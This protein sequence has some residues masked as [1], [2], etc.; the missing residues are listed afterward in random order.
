MIR[1]R[2]IAPL[3]IALAITVAGPALAAGAVSPGMATAGPVAMKAC[4]PAPEPASPR[5]G[6]PGQF[7][8]PPATATN[9]DPFADPKV[10]I[11][12]V[13]GYAYRWQTYDN[14]CVPGS[15]AAP[16]MFTGIGN[17]VL[18]SA[19]SVVAFTHGLLGLVVEPTFLAPLDD[20]ITT[21]T[22]AVKGAFWTP[23]MPIVLLVVAASVLVAAMRANTSTVVTTSGWAAIALIATTYVMDYPVTSAQAV[24][25]LVQNTVVMS[26]RAVGQPGASEST[27]ASA[28]QAGLDAMFDPINRDLL[29]GPWLEGALGS[30]TSTVAKQHGPDLFR[31]SHLTWSEARTVEEDP[32]A[33][34]VI[35]EEKKELWVTT[36]AAVE[37]EDPAAYA[38]LTGKNGRHEA[39]GAVLVRVLFMM[40]FLVI[41]SVIVVL[42]YVATRAFVPLTPAVG[43]IAMVYYSA[44]WVMAVLRNVGKFI[45]YGPAFFVG[46]LL[47]LTLVSAVLKSTLPVPL[48]HVICLALPILLFKILRP[49]STVP[50]MGAARR[51]AREGLRL[52]MTKRAVQDGVEDANDTRDNRQDAA[53]DTVRRSAPVAIDIRP[54]GTDPARDGAAGTQ[55]TYHHAPALPSGQRPDDA[56]RELPAQRT[57]REVTQQHTRRTDAAPSSSTSRD[58]LDVDTRPIPIVL[59]AGVGNHP[60]LT[61]DEPTPEPGHRR[62]GT[63]TATSAGVDDL[64]APISPSAPPPE[65]MRPS[66]PLPEGIVE[67][68]TRIV[69]GHQVFEIWRPPSVAS[70]TTD[71]EEYS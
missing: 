32:A 34:K 27:E 39:T 40:P 5:A 11:T 24:D 23:W 20:T 38:Q 15:D 13:Y 62:H 35:I 3:L 18:S 12:D 61:D 8:D 59:P 21:A 69:D 70:T 26:A 41:A 43:V 50:G 66:A 68:N 51:L 58:E 54:T 14:G 45:I 44:G 31:A 64:S 65:V 71:D 16:S 7:F 53:Q 49:G 57:R 67:A 48:K 28:A 17:F 9:A 52:A 42:G 10:K 46:A 56:P 60:A 55:G 63:T 29:Y 1:R 36:A 37:R 30:S 2:L 4:A 19:A 25:E 47:N 22:A 6:L 33:G